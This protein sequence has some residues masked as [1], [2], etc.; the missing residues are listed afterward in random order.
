M[1]KEKSNKA[2]R[3]WKNNIQQKQNYLGML[4]AKCRSCGESNQYNFSM[5]KYKNYLFMYL[6][7]YIIYVK[8]TN[9]LL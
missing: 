5:Y 4:P 2:K 7:I 9:N 3:I 6:F 1:H 8:V